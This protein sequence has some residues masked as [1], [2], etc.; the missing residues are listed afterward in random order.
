MYTEERRMM[1]LSNAFL[2]LPVVFAGIYHAWLYL[3]LATGLL[4]FSPLYH[5]YSE[6]RPRSPLHVWYRRADVIFARCAFI[7]MYYYTLRYV[8]GVYAVVM[9]ILLSLLVVFFWYAQGSRYERWHPWFHILAP[10]VSSAILFVA[11]G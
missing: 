8:P 1:V 6:Y 9:V 2:I 5:W 10:I 3:F 4:L 7:Y 11:H